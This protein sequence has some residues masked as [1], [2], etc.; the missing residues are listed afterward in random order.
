MVHSN[1]D[2]FFVS[3]VFMV[4][5]KKNTTCLH[6][7]LN[8]LSLHVFTVSILN[9]ECLKGMISAIRVKLNLIDDL[10]IQCI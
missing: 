9:K 5:Y 1:V 10:Q 4:I 8:L 3:V 7:K 6:K 2:N